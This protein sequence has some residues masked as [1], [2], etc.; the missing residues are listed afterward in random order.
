MLKQN[1]CFAMLFNTRVATWVQCGLTPVFMAHVE[2]KVTTSSFCH[3]GEI[4][5]FCGM[6]FCLKYI[7][8][9]VRTLGTFSNFYTFQETLEYF[10]PGQNTFIPNPGQSW[11]LRGA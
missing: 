8:S 10:R 4:F 1:H 5:I 2:T 9:S 6:Y 3:S 7:L 11:V